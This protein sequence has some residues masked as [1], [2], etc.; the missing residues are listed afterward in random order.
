LSRPLRVFINGTS[1]RLGGGITVLKNLLPAL[2]QADGGR[3]H[4]TL[5]LRPETARNFAIENPRVTFVDVPRGMP[6][7]LF[8][9]LAFPALAQA[10]KA[11]V[12][13]SPANVACLPTRIPQVLMF[14]NLLPFDDQVLRVCPPRQLPRLLALRQLGKMSASKARRLVFI[15]DHALTVTA[16]HLS[17]SPSSTRRVYLGRDPAFSPEA[18]RDARPVLERYALRSPFFLSVSQFY[19]Y[20][21]FLELISGFSQALPELGSPAPTLALAGQEC[22]PSYSR[23]VRQLVA[24]LGLQER[25]KL[26][27]HVPYSDLQ[28]LY[29]TADLFLFPS[30]CESFPNIMIESLASGA[31]TLA[32][33]TGPMK[34]LAGSGAAYFDPRSPEE[35]ASSILSYWH[36]PEA[37][38]R[39]AAAGIEAA[40]R[41]SWSQTAVELL[42]S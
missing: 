35:I 12:L 26:L 25:V 30:T 34:E 18:K 27:G 4:Y 20:K 28:T 9:Q 40:H 24:R 38:R 6:R 10:S 22:D 2:L 41:Y 29:A 11:D 32:S 19:F 15:S 8:E 17:A 31:P 16:R 42:A 5:A 13:F 21:N 3:N 7:V 23:S 14:Q 37:R 39:L 1:A 33:S 36:A